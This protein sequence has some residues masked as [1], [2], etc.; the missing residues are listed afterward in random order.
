[1]VY[2]AYMYVCV[3]SLYA[4]FL[5]VWHV[6]VCGAHLCG[7]CGGCVICVCVCCACSKCGMCVV[8]MFVLCLCE[9]CVV[10]CICM[11][12]VNLWRVWCDVCGVFVVYV[13]CL[14]VVWVLCV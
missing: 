7:V 9:L 11:Y 14:F 4:G 12:G 5:C 13:L 2:V 8:Y 1:M 10:Q 3:M 6:C